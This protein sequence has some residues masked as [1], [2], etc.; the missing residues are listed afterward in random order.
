MRVFRGLDAAAEARLRDPVASVGVFDG[1]HRGHRQLLYELTVWS[2]SLGGTACVVTFEEHPRATLEGADVPMILTLEHRLLELERH[3]VE[4]VVLLDFASIQHL[5][6][7]EFLLDVLRDRL[8]CAH[9][10]LG[11]DSHLG[12]GRDG[13]PATLPVMGEE[14][15]IEVRVASP[16]RDKD[17]AKVGSSSIRRA[18]QT[19]DLEGAANV[20]GRPVCLRGTVV[21]GAGRGTGMG[22]ATANLDVSGQ[23]LP[24]DGVYL[25]R[26]FLGS[27]TAPAI[28]NL[29]VQPT[30]GEGAPRRLEVHIPEWDRDLYG[31]AIEVRLVRRIREERRFETPEALTAQI[32]SD[33]SELE[34]S[35]AAGEI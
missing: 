34:R 32:Q 33:L 8:G 3:G 18:I 11:F 23:V 21:P 35:V 10:L 15:G 7:R 19:G 5:P 13:T 14:L 31:E 1:V 6:A 29:G 30:F 17:G 25:V 24:P 2:Q 12:K 27:E 4:A 22:V 26:V 28:A 9:L 20:L 16:V